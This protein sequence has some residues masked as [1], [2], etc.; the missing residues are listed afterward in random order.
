[1]LRAYFSRLPLTDRVTHWWD[2]WAGL[3]TG[4]FN[5][6]CIAFL[7]IAARRVGVSDAGM[8]LMLTMPYV[9]ALSGILLGHLAERHGPMPFYLWPTLA[10]RAVLL[11]LTLARGPTGFLIVASAFHLLANLG[12]PPYA[13][14]MRSNF[15]DEHRGRLMGNVRV[16]VVLV[17]AGTSWA[18]GAALERRPDAWRWLFAG[19]AAV[20]IVAMLFFA[21]IKPRRW[22]PAGRSADSPSAGRPGLRASLGALRR[23]RAFLVFL[24]IVFVCALPSKLAAAL[25][26]IRFVDELHIGWQ[27][28]G[29]VLGTVVSIAGAAGYLAWPRLL[30]RFDAFTLLA[31]VT[32]LTAIRLG[33]IAAATRPLHLVPASVLDGL[34]GG[35]WELMCLFCIVRLADSDH[36]PIAMGL[37][38]TLIGVRGLF[39]PGLGAWI[40][41]SGAMSLPAIFW[42][43]AAATMVGAA[44]LLWYSIRF[45]RVHPAPAAAITR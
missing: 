17:A 35:G 45:R 21:R 38:T 8:A 5:G 15:S 11:A 29:F 14:V 40:L 13:S 37:H 2:L 7:S 23:D 22:I 28:S 26:P 6:G 27:D 24:A 10:S 42:L 41:A 43:L 18:A 3:A 30:K 16:L 1:M 9:G 33:V 20:G 34:T 31:L 4:V 44:G 25:E 39:G 36:F 12:S 32:A 19:A